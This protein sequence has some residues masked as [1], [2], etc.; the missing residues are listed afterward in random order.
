MVCV[1]LP[2]VPADKPTW[3]SSKWSPN[4]AHSEACTR[5]ES[6]TSVLGVADISAVSL[7]AFTF[8]LQ[9]ASVIILTFT[10]FFVLLINTNETKKYITHNFMG[11]PKTTLI[12]LINYGDV[13][14]GE[15]GLWLVA[16]KFLHSRHSC[17]CNW[18]SR[19]AGFFGN[20]LGWFLW[21]GRG[22][23]GLPPSSPLAGWRAAENH[24]W[25][26]L[27]LLQWVD[28]RESLHNGTENQKC[29]LTMQKRSR[30]GSV[31][32]CHQM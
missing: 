31:L 17:W 1:S 3:R 21:L 25:T 16:H 28:R 6:V 7:S 23:L 11:E 5:E 13:V 2:V 26:G 19:F 9:I 8:S 27:C 14:D 15:P 24:S 22:L 4:R 32:A 20:I 18:G 29:K 30:M 12:H 10:Y